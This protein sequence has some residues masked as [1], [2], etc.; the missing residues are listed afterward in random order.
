MASTKQIILAEYK[1]AHNLYNDFCLEM[2]NLLQTI[3][4]KGK[5]KYH[6]S[7]RLKDITSL[8][9]KIERKKNN[10]TR[11]KNVKDIEDIA[12]IRVVFYTE[13]DKQKF[14]E[15]L[16]KEFGNSME[17]QEAKG[18]HGY[19]STHIIAS[20]GEKNYELDKYKK[21]KDLKCEIQLTLILNHAW[22]E[23]EHDLLYKADIRIS[24]ID[25]KY[26]ES[27]KTR[28]EIIMSKYIKQASIE[29]DDIVQEIKKIKLVKK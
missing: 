8:G 16:K 12:G 6:I 4:A 10:G 27:L 17:I 21:F 22:A 29:L 5:Y 26:Y 3:L 13:T 18:L 23:V 1:N 24:K 19:S 7:N 15:R 14:I 2:Y 11:Y 9:E 28:M 25:P 20:L